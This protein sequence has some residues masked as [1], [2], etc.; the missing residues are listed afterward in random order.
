M[1]TRNFCHVGP[2]LLKLRISS[3]CAE[4]MR[5]LKQRN[6]I[7]RTFFRALFCFKKYHR[8]GAVI[9]TVYSTLQKIHVVQFSNKKIKKG[10][11]QCYTFIKFSKT[12]KRMILN[13]NE[14]NE[15]KT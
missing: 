15:K 4:M 13:F 12:T 2:G 14:Q 10:T 5:I 11:W 6:K 8:I 9:G 1:R 7:F 3:D